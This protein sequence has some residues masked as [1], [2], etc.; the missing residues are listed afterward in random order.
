M[1]DEKIIIKG[2]REHNL[3][4][5]DVEIPK[6]KLVVFTGVSGSGKSSLAFDTIYAEGQRRYVESLSSYARQFLGVMDKPDLDNITGLSPAISI[7]QK[8]TSHNP[9]STVG[10]I[11][12]IYDYLRLLFARIGHPHCP[13]CGREIEHLSLDQIVEQV[14]KLGESGKLG[15]SGKRFLIL[16]P[17]VKGRKGEYTQ[18]FNSLRAKGIIKVRVDKH[19]YDVD[20]DIVLI[21]T[22]KHDIEAVVDRITV[23]KVTEVNKDI[24]R[25][26]E[27]VEKALKLAAGEIIVSEVLDASFEFPERPAK[28]EDHLFSEKFACPV[29]NISLSEIEPRL[30]SFNSPQGAC[31]RCTG[32]GF[33]LK[34]D[35]E[36]VI[37]PELSVLEGGILPMGNEVEHDTWFIRMVKAVAE[38]HNFSLS[39]PIGQMKKENLNLILFGTGEEEIHVTGTNREGRMTGFYEKFEGVIPR[40][41]RLYNETESE[42]RR[43]DIEKYMRNEPCPDCHGAKLKPE[44][45]SVTIDGQNIFQ[46]TTKSISEVLR[47]VKTLTNIGRH[48]QTLAD[49]EKAISKPIFKELISRLQFLE[50]VGLDY[51]TLG[52]SANTLAGGEAQRI[53]LA[54]QIGSGLSGVL[55]VLDEPSIG[56]HQRDN[57]RLISTL[58]NLRDLGNSVIVVE[59]DR[60]MMEKADY[61]FDFGPGAGEHGGEIIAQ[62]TPV[63][64]KKDPNSITGKY[65]SGRK[66]IEIQDS[67]RLMTE[68]RFLMTENGKQNGEKKLV[69][70]G[71]REHNLKNI[72]VEF[73]LGKFIV[74]TGVSGSGKSTLVHDILY[75]ALAGKFYPLHKEKPGNFDGLLGWEFLDKVILIDQS[76][77]GRT[78]RS[79]PATYTGAFTPIREIFAQTR[80]AR[81]KGYEAGRFSFN[82]KGGRCEACQGEGQIK[83]EMQ[84]LPDIYVDCEV[85]GGKRYNQEALGVLYKNKNIAEVL[86]MTV[87]EALEFFAPIPVLHEKLQTLT[88]VG[89]GYLKLGQPAPTLSGGEAQR[90]KLAAELSKKATGKTVYILDEPT[91]GLHFADLERL[92]WV[93]KSLVN[94]GNTVIV[95][96]HN[97]DVIKNADYLIDLGPEGGDGGGQIVATGTPEEVAKAKESWTGR[98]L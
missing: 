21:K 63:Q 13:N 20:D 33:L 64:I 37:N 30:F 54:S 1:S 79:N 10:T 89:L 48:W 61:I 25:L 72:D 82:V 73:P 7:D 47:W 68:E 38:K 98:Y 59:H 44:A 26:R 11:T 84:F 52:R 51:L 65:L 46:V 91:T 50:D 93:L 81:I 31:P 94:K 90:V 43:M 70:L 97:L 53:R 49:R 80:E 92:L 74:V 76:P 5:I 67:G 58:S 3:K 88:D 66:E 96:E 75:Q 4:N 14:Q 55:Y 34:I 17:V 12:E 42:W 78:P 2:A 87:E 39:S 45:L 8:T 69:L 23:T 16:A 41:E 22:N 19:I 15:R 71:A 35:P 95:I 57:Q 32:L 6:N 18:L 40:M 9:R 56:L 77:I 29:C 36:L 83:I 85:C 28:M 86:A 60:E 27:S 24:S 62:G